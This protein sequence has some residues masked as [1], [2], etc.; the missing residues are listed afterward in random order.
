MT[1]YNVNTNND[2]V[3]VYFK[4]HC[5]RVCCIKLGTTVHYILICVFEA[6]LHDMF[7]NNRTNM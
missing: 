5:D 2:D 4:D 1:L 6:I 7:A 3:G